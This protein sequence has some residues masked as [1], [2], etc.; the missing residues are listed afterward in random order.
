MIWIIYFGYKGALGP[1]FLTI[2][3]FFFLYMWYWSFLPTV[4]A[5][6]SFVSSIDR[7]PSPPTPFPSH[8]FGL[9][10][11]ITSPSPFLLPDQHH[12]QLHFFPFLAISVSG[13]AVTVVGA[14]NLH[15]HLPGLQKNAIATTNIW[16]T[17]TSS[18][19]RSF[20]SSSLLSRLLHLLWCFL[21]LL[22]FSPS[23]STCVLLPMLL[24]VP[25]KLLLHQGDAAPSSAAWVIPLHRELHLLP[26]DHQ[27]DS[28][29]WG[30]HSRTATTCGT[31]SSFFS[32]GRLC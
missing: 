2:S 20:F 24:L 1:S 16:I 6:F 8:F 10:I 12:H 11:S 31:S 13:F 9:I 28:D 18:S 3:F 4:Q 7:A 14:M 27:V 5:F 32:S 29:G 23:I 15:F 21:L 30:G 17:T 19:F 22:H 25:R 26:V